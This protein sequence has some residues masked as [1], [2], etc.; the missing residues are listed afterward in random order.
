[1]SAT[2]QV[3]RIVSLA[4][5]AMD[6]PRL[7]TFFIL[8]AGRCGTTSLA[9]QLRRHPGVFIPEIKEPSFFASSF[10]WVRDPWKYVDLYADVGDATHLGDASHIYLED[11][12]S[13]Q[14]LEAF[15]P[16]ARFIL[17]FRNPAD[18]ALAMYAQMVEWGY[19][20]E[21]TFERG[22]AAEDRRFESQ[23]FRDHCPHSFWNFMYFR[24]GLFGEQVARYLE[25]WPRDRFY[26]TTMYEYLDEP[27]RVTAEI[28]AF[29]DL[30]P[31]DLGDVPHYGS[32]K[33][34]RSR[35]LQYVERRLLR[36]LMRRNVPGASNL[37]DRV[38]AWNRGGER[39]KMQ[40]G[41]RDELIARYRPDLERLNQFL[42]VDVLGREHAASRIPQADKERPGQVSGAT[43]A[44]E[45]HDR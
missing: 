22:L 36:P 8:G 34:T 19:E 37:R 14:I 32:S 18:R 13:P 23:R 38:I 5:P 44:C 41:T 25:R 33:G 39:P 29:L 26:A 43:P 11:P 21:P 1:M 30:E 15:F 31:R 12:K 40:E 42:A 4:S 20:L 7:P 3:G 16:G 6:S 10:Q 9:G 17:M 2:R 24:S 45:D 35:H 28:L 27:A